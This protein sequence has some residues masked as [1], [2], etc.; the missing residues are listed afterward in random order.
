MSYNEEPSC[1]SDVILYTI[2][3]SHVRVLDRP[4]NHLLQI[5]PKQNATLMPTFLINV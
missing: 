1:L 2:I 4:G 5:S 3:I